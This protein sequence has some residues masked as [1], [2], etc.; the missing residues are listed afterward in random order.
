[1]RENDHLI[2][3]D[4][5]L[6]LEDWRTDLE[7]GHEEPVFAFRLPGDVKANTDVSCTKAEIVFSQAYW[8]TFTFN[9]EDHMYYK[10]HSGKPQID[11]RAEEGA[12]QL[13][14]RNLIILQSDEYYQGVYRIIDMS[15]GTGYYISEGAIQEIRWEKDGLTSPVRI[16]T[17]DGE[18]VP[19]NAGKTYVALVDY[20]ADLSFE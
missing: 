9:E 14:F 2:W 6:N 13:F 5:R 1:M 7:E 10:E 17:P 19:V 20:S 12:N 15:G 16:M 3:S 4:A 18:E 8:S 11:E